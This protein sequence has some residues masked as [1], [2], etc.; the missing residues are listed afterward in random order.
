MTKP[1]HHPIRS[2]FSPISRR[3]MLRHAGC[4]FG[5]WA[6]LDLATRDGLLHAAPATSSEDALAPKQPHFRARAKHVI[7]LFMQ[8][9]PSQIDTFDPKPILSERHGQPLPES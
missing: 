7:F 2:G 3:D 4:G 8:G 5:A 6:L 1:C 9:G